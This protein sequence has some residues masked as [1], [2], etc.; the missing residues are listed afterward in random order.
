MN[1]FDELILSESIILKSLKKKAMGKTVHNDYL[2][3]FFEFKKVVSLEAKF[4]VQNFPEY[5]PHD[6]EHHLRRLLN[7]ADE[8]LGPKIIKSLNATELLILSLSI[9]GH[10]WGMAVSEAEKKEI[11]TKDDL[12]KSEFSL[13]RF[14]NQDFLKHLKR[15]NENLDNISNF[16]WQEYIRLTHAKR[17]AER[18]KRYF[19]KIDNGIGEATARTCEGHWLDFKEIKNSV[20]YPSNYMVRGENVN[21]RAIT[22]YLRLIDLFDI[23]NE[24]TPYTIYKYTAPQSI[25]S[26]MEWSKHYAI[27]SLATLDF[28]NGRIIQVDGQTDDF[29]VFAALEDL[30]TFCKEQLSGCNDLL[31][32]MNDKKYYLNIFEIKWNIVP[33]DFD[34]ISIKFEFDRKRMFE[35]LSDEIYKGDKYVF[36]RELLQNSIDAIKLRKEW[37][38][39]K[40]NIS[41]SSFGEINI[42]VKK[43]EEKNTEIIFT[44]DG[45]GMDRYIVENYLS[46]AGKSYYHSDEFKRLGLELDPISRFGVGILSCFMIANKVNI[47]TLKDPLIEPNSE[48]LDIDIPDV[49]KQF[50]I[51]KH[52][53]SNDK[54]GTTISIFI[55]NDEITSQLN[56]TLELDITTYLKNLVGV[57]E[58]PIIINENQKKTVIINPY[59]NIDS[60]KSKYPESDIFSVQTSVDISKVFLPQS[61]KTAKEIFKI[62][63]YIIEDNLSSKGEQGVINFIVPKDPSIKIRQ[64]GN[65]WPNAEFHIIHG[66]YRQK[67]KIDEEW[68]GYN[69]ATMPYDYKYG[70][71]SYS[72]IAYKVLLDGI[73]LP[74]AKPPSKIEGSP[75]SAQ[76]ARFQS[77]FPS[78]RFAVPFVFI[79][80]QKGDFMN[81]DLSRTEIRSKEKYW[82]SDISQKLFSH[83]VDLN[84]QQLLDKNIKARIIYFTYLIFFYRIPL[85]LIIKNI[86]LENCPFLLMTSDGHI[87]FDVWNNWKDRTVYFQ[88]KYSYWFKDAILREFNETNIELN[89][90]HIWN[91]ED[92]VLQNIMFPEKN[93]EHTSSAQVILSS[94]LA[95]FYIERTHKFHSYRFISSP[96]IGSPALIQSIFVPSEQN[97]LMHDIDVVYLA[98]TEIDAITDSNTE[99]LFNTLSYEITAIFQIDKLPEIGLFQ[100][101]YNECIAYGVTVLN[102]S[103][104]FTKKILRILACILI[105]EENKDEIIVEWARLIDQLFELPFFNSDDYFYEKFSLKEINK[106]IEEINEIIISNNLIK[107]YQKLQCLTFDNF[108]ENT[109]IDI[110]DD[111]YCQFFNFYD[112]DDSELNDDYPT[113]LS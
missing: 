32:E 23:S 27:N 52:I 5:T 63:Q 89:D 102:S 62:D 44:D 78:E 71:S 65:S 45:I 83:I 54:V 103:H 93:L 82:D 104:N 49:D 57:V 72:D 29:R 36:I 43:D 56:K 4:I 34:P 60:Y 68:M 105:Y 51:S 88:P 92:F 15:L 16:A 22:L 31:Q 76:L 110:G 20:I 91:N 107:N 2:D 3:I 111:D 109:V 80:F 37:I 30:H 53:P 101:P 21:L 87:K 58:F 64:A 75:Y 81:T 95:P 48:V 99:L 40:H 11:L 84:R 9:F 28:N 12:Q 61:L 39:K 69:I 18:V 79:N 33:I 47:V 41:L 50:R 59:E 6:E 46:V 98:A 112:I 100:A 96:N 74:K 13:L 108:V 14:D 55:S 85:D 97:V 1:K 24:R 94:Q 10:D 67:V 73:L 35:V 70:A 106:N 77:Y 26:K 113:V 90:L 25:R 19:K 42:E 38:E 7:L 66:K 86:G 8:I 17:S